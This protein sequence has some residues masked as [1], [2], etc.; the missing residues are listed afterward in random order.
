[1]SSSLGVDALLLRVTRPLV[2]LQVQQQ[3]HVRSQILAWLYVRDFISFPVS[4][5]QITNFK[6]NFLKN[7]FYLNSTKITC[8]LNL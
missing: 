2:W 7:I 8:D 5:N 1:M 6:L 3:S 4:K